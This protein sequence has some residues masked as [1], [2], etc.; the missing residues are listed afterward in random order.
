MQIQPVK[1]ISVSRKL[2][3]MFHFE[4]RGL[5]VVAS[6]MVAAPHMKKHSWCEV[7]EQLSPFVP[8]GSVMS[9]TA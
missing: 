3:R 1:Q 7:L 9:M 2:T 6:P 5:R 4:L 8:D